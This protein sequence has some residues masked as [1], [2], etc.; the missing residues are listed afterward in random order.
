MPVVILSQQL[1]SNY[2]KF[3]GLQGKKS[4]EA[5]TMKIKWVITAI[6]KKLSFHIVPG[7]RRL[8]LPTTPPACMPTSNHTV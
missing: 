3:S 1:P 6:K 5:F 4:Y 2:R 8:I 7:H